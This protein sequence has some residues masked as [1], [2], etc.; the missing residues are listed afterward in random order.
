MQRP[1]QAHDRGTLQVF[2]A[3]PSRPAATVP[4]R[5]L[6]RRK[7]SRADA[8]FSS[9][10]GEPEHGRWIVAPAPAGRRQATRRRYRGDTLILETEFD[11][12]GGTVRVIDLMP[13]R[14]SEVDLV[15][16]VEGVSGSV[17]MESE[18][19]LRFQY[20]SVVPWVRRREDGPHLRR[21]LTTTLLTGQ[22][23]RR[24]TPRLSGEASAVD[25]S[26][27]GEM[28]G[29]LP[30]MPHGGRPFCRVS[31]RIRRAAPIVRTNDLLSR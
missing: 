23:W 13:I 2:G 17:R 1:C 3:R 25:T 7:A 30:L 22:R 31:E 24:G 18:L 11:T 4:S 16:I 8:C 21:V 26:A 14:H 10:L 6:P 28:R 27:G 19:V 5:G 12:D 20:G 15:R 9:L 29:G